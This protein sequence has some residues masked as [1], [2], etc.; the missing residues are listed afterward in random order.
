MPIGEEPNTEEVDDRVAIRIGI[1]DVKIVERYSFHSS[2]LQQPAAF[3]LSLSGARGLAELLRRYRWGTTCALYIGQYRQFT[4]EIDATNP[5]G[6]ASRTMLDITGRDLMARFH[7]Q[8]IEGEF[9]IENADYDSLVRL[10]FADCGLANKIIEISNDANRKVK[11]G[12]GVKVV[13]APIKP[14][15]TKK[16]NTVVAS[17]MGETWLTFFER[18]FKKI[19][20]FLWCD[21]YGNFVLSRPNTDQEPA[22]HFYRTRDKGRRIANVK[23]WALTNDSTGRFADC[24]IFARNQGKKHGH[25]HQHGEFRDEEMANTLKYARRRVFRDVNVNTA[26]EAA[27]YAR[28][29]IA[30]VNRA[31]WKLQY[32]ISGHTAPTLI[33]TAERA[34]VC[35]DMLARVDDDDL[36]IHDDLYIE[37]VEYRAPPRET[38]ITM[39]RTQDILFG[40]SQGEEGK[41]KAV[42]AVKKRKLQDDLPKRDIEGMRLGTLPYG[43]DYATLGYKGDK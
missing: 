18:H 11:S 8:N 32:T 42:A 36:D 30:E 34:I 14:G 25:N 40:E 3:A 19:G 20:L 17:K 27:F 28:R 37:S 29:R 6:D 12:V 7:D 4:G 31:G 22:F 1:D 13:K 41:K 24:V 5:S 16:F 2:I 10:G 39:M 38:V 21:A 43:L 26:E 33:S 35:P 15:E 9:S 23:K